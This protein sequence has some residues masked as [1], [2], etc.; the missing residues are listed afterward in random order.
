M[1][2]LN[3]KVILF[4]VIKNVPPGNFEELLARLIEIVYDHH[5]IRQSMQSFWK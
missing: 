4:Y 2:Y 1:P 5:D 3:V